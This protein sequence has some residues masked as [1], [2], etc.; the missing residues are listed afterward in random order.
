MPE[1]QW[2][3]ATKLAR[4]PKALTTHA[5][6]VGTTG[7]PC[8]PQFP[9]TGGF[10]QCGTGS[11]SLLGCQQICKA[12]PPPAPPLPACP[13]FPDDD[14][15]A[16]CT[17]ETFPP[18]LGCR[19]ETP[20]FNWIL[21]LCD[22]P[23]STNATEN[24]MFPGPPGS[25]SCSNPQ[26]LQPEHAGPSAVDLLYIASYQWGN[27]CDLALDRWCGQRQVRTN[28]TRC[29]HCAGAH[30]EALQAAGCSAGDIAAACDPCGAAL[31]TET[32]AGE[33]ARCG[34]LDAERCE[35]CMDIAQPETGHEA[36]CVGQDV[37]ARLRSYCRREKRWVQVVESSFNVDA[38]NASLDLEAL[39]Q[40]GGV[41]LFLPGS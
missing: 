8:I 27:P 24:T 37:G 6:F 7:Q 23:N 3:V 31:R 25:F 34:R 13:A 4:T 36:A 38:R 30:A 21:G 19:G 12:P 29:E 26:R 32:R 28:S 14:D 35:V 10:P 40:A 16:A 39:R 15:P 18:P 41:P 1:D 22:S 9:S 20:R 11:N 2:Y 33:A 5:V 17:C